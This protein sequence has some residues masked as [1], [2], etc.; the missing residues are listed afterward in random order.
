MVFRNKKTNRSDK[1][2]GAATISEWKQALLTPDVF[3]FVVAKAIQDGGFE[4]VEFTP[5]EFMQSL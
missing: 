4:F 1:Y 3:R 5:T 2:F